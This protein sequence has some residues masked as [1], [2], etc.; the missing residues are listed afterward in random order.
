MSTFFRALAF[1]VAVCCLTWVGVLWWWQR[2]G[3][4]IEL[5]DVVIYL[6]LLPLALVLL[7]LTLRWAWRRA[8]ASSA[9]A[10]GV[11]AGAAVGAPSSVIG[12]QTSGEE[13][14][15]HAV[16]Q[17]VHAACFSVAGDQSSD[18][19]DAAAAGKPLPQPDGDLCNDDGLP[20]LCARIPDKVLALESTRVEVD[21]LLPQVQ[22]RQPEWQGL[23][24]GEDVP[25]ALAALKEPLLSQQS[26]LL[27]L[28]QTLK[29]AVDD[30]GESLSR[31]PPSQRPPLP[32]LRVLLGWP[33][34]WS[35]FEQ[36]V[37]RS[38]VERLL[39][40]PDTDLSRAYAVSYASLAGA[41]EDLWLRAD[42]MCQPASQ[43]P[44][45]LVAA[46]HSEVGQARV[47]ALL[48]AQRLYDASERPGGCLPGEAAAAL[49]LAPAHW[50]PPQ[51]MD[52]SPVK[53]HR[54]ALTRR[55]KPVEASGRIDHRELAEAFAQALMAAEIEAPLLASLVC[56]A[57]QHSQ[58]SAELYGVVVDALGH[59]DPVEDV[60]LLGKITGYTGAASW[61][62]V[63]AA[64]AA[65][66]QASKKNTLALGLAD[67]HLRMALVLKPHEASDVA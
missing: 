45:L 62:L 57:D 52:L 16:M 44:W 38:W 5:Q 10:A 32:G 51:E 7:L 3:H 64:A 2:S 31:L 66:A 40:G 20:V 65:A 29:N 25:R 21:A 60:R 13:Q 39:C 46:C 53:L 42:Q 14:A 58:R 33:Q 4:N 37:A 22:Q 15:R 17:L 56:D 19:L 34:H 55:A 26:W 36:A 48:A 43:T 49:L 1:L 28:D 12:G 11:A 47:D 27:G 59:L 9:A 24:L 23:E 8:G 41:G 30:G 63:L 61:L 6:G 67:S 35:G 50:T 18:L 54:P